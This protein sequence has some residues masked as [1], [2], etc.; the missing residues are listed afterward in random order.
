MRKRIFFS[1]GDPSGDTHTAAL[2]GEIYRQVPEA[3]CRGLGGDQ[4]AHAG[5]EIIYP[6]VNHAIVGIFDA[7]RGVPFFRR[8]LRQVAEEFDRNR[9]DMV[10]LVD[11]PGFNWWVAREA[12]KRDITVYYFLPPQIWAWATWRVRKMRRLV[13][14]VL[15]A[16]PF[17]VPWYRARGVPAVFAGHPYW[18]TLRRLPPAPS[19]LTRLR[20]GGRV[21]T[22]LPGS[23]D[24]EVERNGPVFARVAALLREQFPDLRFLAACRTERHAAAV[25]RMMRRAGVPTDFVVGATPH[26]IEVADLCLAKSGSVTLELLWHAR[27]AVVYY[28]VPRTE[29]GIYRMADACGM[30]Q[31]R[32]I[33]LPNIAAGREILP[34]YVSWT[35][36]APALADRLAVWLRDP[37]AA[38]QTACALA[39]VRARFDRVN[40][41]EFTA[42]CILGD[43]ESTR[44]TLRPAA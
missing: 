31:A 38:S 4:M 15:C 9:P 29:Y 2:I 8:L 20:E 42:R 35:D 33:S 24:R 3:R 28:R 21:V 36:L 6:L 11:Y 30:V 10:V 39:Q 43:A 27:P 32:F 16:Y 12:R 18:D 5:C 40:V 41:L 23:R 13:D 1:V 44:V 7:V 25:A 26:A 22:L 14:C 19:T 17:E 34:E 37:D